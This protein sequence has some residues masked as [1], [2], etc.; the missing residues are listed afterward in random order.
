MK[1]TNAG[2][3]EDRA[4][5]TMANS[6]RWRHKNAVRAVVV[7]GLHICN[8]FGSTLFTEEGTCPTLPV[9]RQSHLKAM[10]PKTYDEFGFVHGKSRERGRMDKEE[11]E[12]EGAEAELWAKFRAEK[13]KEEEEAKEKEEKKKQARLSWG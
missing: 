13:K 7:V 3:T 5:N 1:N 11:K 2:R 12:D 6:K 9:V 8:H 4:I 10:P